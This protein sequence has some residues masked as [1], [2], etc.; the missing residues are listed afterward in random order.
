RARAI[1]L[2]NGLR[3]AYTGNI[4]DREGAT[5]FCHGC[6][7]PVIHRDVYAIAGYRLT[8]EGRCGSCGTQCAGVF[9]GPPGAWGTRRLPVWIGN[10]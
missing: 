9:A 4:R 2:R 10:A 6:G 5:T 3:Y 7:K 1:A 8:A